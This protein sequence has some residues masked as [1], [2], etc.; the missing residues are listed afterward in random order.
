M[1]TILTAVVTILKTNFP[2][3][4]GIEYFR[5]SQIIAFQLQANKAVG[6]WEQFLGESLFL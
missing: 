1:L 5:Y 6:K 2:N 4:Y 3:T